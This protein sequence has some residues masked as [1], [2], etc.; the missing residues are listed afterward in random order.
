L[1]KLTFFLV[2][3]TVENEERY[4]LCP[5]NGNL[6]TV[7]KKQPRPLKICRISLFS[8]N[9]AGPFSFQ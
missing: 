4:S 3:Y 7:N 9:Q 2:M 6:P 8:R 5:R 1:P